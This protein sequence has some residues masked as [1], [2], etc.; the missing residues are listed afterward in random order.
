MYYANT[1]FPTV[2]S[3]SSARDAEYTSC[4]TRNPHYFCSM[5]SRFGN[6][7]WYL[8]FVLHKHVITHLRLSVQAISGFY[9]IRVPFQ[10]ATLWNAYEIRSVRLRAWNNSRC[11]KQIFTNVTLGDFTKVWWLQAFLIISRP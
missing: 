1:G 2:R 5:T 8:G 10:F 7:W 3:L 6:Y 9:F 4:Q 11:A